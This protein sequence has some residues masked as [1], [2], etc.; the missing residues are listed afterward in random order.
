MRPQGASLGGTYHSFTRSSALGQYVATLSGA[1]TR[2]EAHNDLPDDLPT[3][4]A[5]DLLSARRDPSQL[6]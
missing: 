5:G 3:S 4:K 6:A 1:Y 2:C